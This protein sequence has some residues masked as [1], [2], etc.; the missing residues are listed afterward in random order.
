[1]RSMYYFLEYNF[2]ASIT[3][4]EKTIIKANEIITEINEFIK[5]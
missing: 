2:R 4:Y 3:D 5:K 1:M